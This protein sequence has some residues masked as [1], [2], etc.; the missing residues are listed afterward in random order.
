MFETTKQRKNY[1]EKPSAHMSG[2]DLWIM[3]GITSGA[4]DWW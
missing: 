3:A 1:P 2:W 4:Y